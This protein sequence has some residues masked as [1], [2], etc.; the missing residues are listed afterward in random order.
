LRNIRINGLERRARILK[1]DALTAH[2]RFTAVD[3]L[4][5]DISNDGDTYRQVF[6]RWASKV[7]GVMLLEGGS[8]ERDRVPWMAQFDKAPIVPAIEEIRRSY[9]QW[10]LMVVT[11]FPSLTVAMRTRTA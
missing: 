5:V 1:A 4:H 10:V 3:W 7:R 2:E 8:P 11:P 6:S 9:P